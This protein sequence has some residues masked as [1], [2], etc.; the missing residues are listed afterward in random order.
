MGGKKSHLGKGK[1]YSYELFQPPC[2][3]HTLHFKML[4]HQPFSVKC[5]QPWL[6]WAI[7]C[8]WN[9][10]FKQS[11]QK[12]QS[13]DKWFTIQSI[14]PHS[15]CG[16]WPFGYIHSEK[17]TCVPLFWERTQ[18]VH[19]ELEVHKKAV[20]LKRYLQRIEQTKP[21][22]L[23]CRKRACCIILTEHGPEALGVE[24]RTQSYF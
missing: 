22:V 1:K 20:S 21:E 7:S 3:C 4:G 5:V 10:L 8:H 16:S 24:A 13:Q 15:F 9:L 12:L 23:E 19:S 14:L 11:L 18:S 2:L 17:Q 6:A